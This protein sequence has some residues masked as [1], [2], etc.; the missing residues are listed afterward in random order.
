[1]EAVYIAL[2]AVVQ[3]VVLASVQG[4]IS[5]RKDKRDRETATEKEE[6]D[7]RLQAEKEER[8]YARQDKVAERVAKAA[9]EVAVVAE[10]AANAA[11][12]LAAAQEEAKKRTEEVARLAAEA[13]ERTHQQLV[14]S[15][16]QL[17]KIHTLV[18]SDMTAARTAER[19]A[20]MAL[21]LALKHTKALGLHLERTPSGAID[22][23]IARAEKRVEELDQILA[24]RLAAQREV[25]AQANAYNAGLA[26][27]AGKPA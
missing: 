4:W 3:L 10:E 21:V 22:E 15:A 18:N 24:D 2:I 12:L 7:A 5:S 9:Q 17:K 23:E 25:D 6:R 14:E 13:D 26:A 27:Q 20:T 1:M 16:E 8:D 11:R 19:T